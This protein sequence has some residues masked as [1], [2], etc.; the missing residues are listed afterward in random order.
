MMVLT[1]PVLKIL[2]L[3]LAI[4]ILYMYKAKISCDMPKKCVI[5]FDLL[6]M[7]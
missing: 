3:N 2:E 1:D 4:I 5:T 6:K 7:L